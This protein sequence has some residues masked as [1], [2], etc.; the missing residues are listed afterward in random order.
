M[1]DEHNYLHQGAHSSGTDGSV[2]I[3]TF[4]RAPLFASCGGGGYCSGWQHSL[5]G[6]T[7][8]ATIAADDGRTIFVTELTPRLH[9][10]LK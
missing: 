10:K 4:R 7:S 8:S 2:C 9:V 6:V 3:L 1:D 5:R